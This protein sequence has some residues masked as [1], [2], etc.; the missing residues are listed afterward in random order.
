MN[1]EGIT[2][3]FLFLDA[4]A[5]KEHRMQML[6][7][8]CFIARGKH[9]KNKKVIGIATEMKL[10]LLCSYDFCL[11]E[12]PRWTKKNQEDAEK[13][14]KETGILTRTTRR[15]VSEDEFPKN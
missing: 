2:Y 8:L 1:F 14:Q 13:L 11:F 4:S 9:R 10:E 7:N 15:E 6:S 12:K 3:C 5:K